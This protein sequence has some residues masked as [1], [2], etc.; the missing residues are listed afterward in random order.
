MYVILY[1]HMDAAGDILEEG[2]EDKEEEFTSC[3]RDTAGL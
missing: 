1:H 2:E 3:L